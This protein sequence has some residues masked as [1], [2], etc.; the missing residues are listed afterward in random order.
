MLF[1]RLQERLIKKLGSNAFP[2][3]FTFPRHSPISVTL[4]PE[5][6]DEVIK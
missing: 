2:F 1:N 3:N 5:E 6:G 4:Q